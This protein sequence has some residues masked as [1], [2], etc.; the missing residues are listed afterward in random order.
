MAKQSDRIKNEA[1][2]TARVVEDAFRGISE[3]IGEYFEDALSKG[4]DVS[5]NM[6]KDV[7]GSLNS[8]SRVSKDLASNFEKANRGLLKQ[9][10]YTKE[11]QERNAKLAAIKAQ[12]GIA[13][14]SGVGNAKELN[15]EYEKVL[16]Y[17]GFVKES[18]FFSLDL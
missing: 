14:R 13:E 18:S 3:K 1:Q 17:K 16:K 12:I 15:K 9:K 11:I 6:V 2:E 4:E 5:K 10:D 7:Q 8:L